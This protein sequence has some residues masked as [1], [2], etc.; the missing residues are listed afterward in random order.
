MGLVPGM[1]YTFV[2]SIT[3]VRGVGQPSA[4]SLEYRTLDSCDAACSQSCKWNGRDAASWVY[5]LSP[6]LPSFSAFVLSMGHIA[7]IAVVSVIF[8]AV[9]VTLVACLALRQYK[10]SSLKNS[11]SLK[12]GRNV[13]ANDSGSYD[14]RRLVGNVC[15]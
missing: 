12:V 5:S 11:M 2:V 15:I 6:F 14:S 8:L 3:N 4:A 10:K 9:V 1:T 13:Y 7:G